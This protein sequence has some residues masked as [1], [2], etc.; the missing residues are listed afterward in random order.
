M[1]WKT[2]I[3]RL[4]TQ[5][6]HKIDKPLE[7]QGSLGDGTLVTIKN[8][9]F[10]YD[11]H[12]EDAGWL[13]QH[14]DARLETTARILLCGPNGSGKSTFVRL[15]LGQLQPTSGSLSEKG[16]R[17]LYF[18]QTALGELATQHGH[19]TALSFLGGGEEGH[20]H[21]NLTQTE[22]ETETETETRMQLGKFGLTK[23]A[24]LRTAGSLSTGQ[25]VRVWLAK[26]CVH[27]EDH[28]LLIMDEISE[29]LDVQTRQSVFDILNIFVGAVVP[30][31][32][33]KDFCVSFRPTHIWSIRNQTVAASFPA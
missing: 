10:A 24:A 4:C 11:P 30:I 25:R 9:D 2:S 20:D 28:T 6:L 12:D 14:L 23:Q 22:T 3:S 19:E 16:T 15:S 1:T 27:S 17:V 5:A 26:Q 32:H 8:M 18:P 7:I 21:N 33:D 29:N 13:F 31:S